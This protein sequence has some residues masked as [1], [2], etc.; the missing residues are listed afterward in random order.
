MRI[1]EI[2]VLGPNT[3]EKQRFLTSIADDIEMTSPEFSFGRL[4]IN[5]QLL[6]HLYGVTLQPD[7]KTFA[8]DLIGRKVL[9]CIILFSWQDLTSF[10]LIKPVID[11]I[12]TRYNTA[13]VVAAH[14]NSENWPDAEMFRT[15]GIALTPE[16]KFTFCDVDDPESAKH[17][18]LALVNLLI[19]KID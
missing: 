19:D 16:G 10:E 4:T 1:G 8:W 9:G 12:S 3:N 18:L 7:A 5:N 17:V 6:L 11:Q 15:G 2:V 13:M 14:M